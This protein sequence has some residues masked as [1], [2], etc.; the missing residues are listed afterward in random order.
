MRRFCIAMVGVVLVASA[1]AGCGGDSGAAPGS[2]FLDDGSSA[3]PFKSTDMTPFESMKQQT[4]D[5][6]K[7]RTYTKKATPPK[8][9][10]KKKQ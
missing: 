7:N 5:H 1:F 2:G 8:E 3:V 10:E 9:D 4:Q 6:M